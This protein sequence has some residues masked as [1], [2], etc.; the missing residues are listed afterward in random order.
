MLKGIRLWRIT[1]CLL[2]PLL[3]LTSSGCVRVKPIFINDSDRVYSG[4]A[5]TQPPTPEFSWV[6]MS[7]GQYRKITTVNP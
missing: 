5:N 4:E 6:L 7:K 3:L 1:I 2:F